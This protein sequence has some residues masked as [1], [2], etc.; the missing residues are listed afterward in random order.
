M[1]DYD[2]ITIGGGLGGTSL[3]IAMAERG[4]KVLVLERETQFRD[5]VR[6][7]GLVPW[8]VAEANELGILGLLRSSCAHE[9]PLWRVLVNGEASPPRPLPETTPSGM[10]V[11]TFYHPAMQEALLTAAAAVGVEVR[12]G[13]IA[14]E[15]R[16][17]SPAAVVFEDGSGTTERRARLVVGADGRGTALRTCA[18]F[19]EKR[20]PPG[21]RISGVLFEDMR[22]VPPDTT[23]LAFDVNVGHQAIAF[24]EGGGRVRCYVMSS[25]KEDICL[26]GPGDVPRFKELAAGCGMPGEFF[27]RAT[28]GGPLATFDGAA[29]WVEEP[30]RDGIAL[31]G[32]AAGVS[33]P[34]WGQGLSLALRGARVLRDALS[35]SEDWGAG[36]RAYAA[37]HAATFRKM[38][39]VEGIFE[40]LVMTR[41]RDADAKRARALPL[42]AE[43]PM[44]MP[45]HLLCGPDLP[46]EGPI[47]DIYVS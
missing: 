11:L 38:H 12:R 40:N 30:Y 8:G 31:L 7:E 2:I 23:H 37:E 45:D 17:G 27:E 35:Y 26:A 22:G 6:G 33:D 18:G 43:D 20:A 39:A 36:G 42:L 3:S 21:L 44:A 4:A 25:H 15:V 29:S 16:P 5:R 13:A 24:P 28:V 32:D 14:R 41:G 9:V 10:P 19:E 47:A 1:R 34:S 46:L